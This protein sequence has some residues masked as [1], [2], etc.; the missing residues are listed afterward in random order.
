[1]KDTVNPFESK[2]FWSMVVGVIMTIIVAIIPELEQHIDTL[3][4][5]ILAIVGIAIGGFTVQDQAKEKYGNG[6]ATVT[7][8]TSTS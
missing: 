6:A 4:P 2:K 7:T 1:M 3:V 8:D 5:A